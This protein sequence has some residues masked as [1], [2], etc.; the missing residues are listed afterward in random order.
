MKQREEDMK[1][2]YCNRL[3][4]GCTWHTAAKDEAELIH[5]V[6]DHLRS[7]HGE[8]MIRP[9]MVEMIKERIEEKTSS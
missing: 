5:K 6:T 2:F 8:T 1:E 3:V 4:P 7:A 9:N